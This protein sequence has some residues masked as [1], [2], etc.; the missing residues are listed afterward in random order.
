M[1]AVYVAAFALL[2]GSVGTTFADAFIDAYSEPSQ[3]LVDIFFGSGHKALRVGI[4]DSENHFTAVLTG[5]KIV[6]ESSAYTADMKGAGRRRSE[7]H[8][9]FPIFCRHSYIKSWFVL[10]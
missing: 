10:Y 2:V 8:T 5:E 1:L 3:G 9:H 7:A 6:E 4:L